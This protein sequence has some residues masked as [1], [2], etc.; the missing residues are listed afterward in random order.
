MKIILTILE[1][2]LLITG[3]VIGVLL[4]NYYD[5]RKIEG[6]LNVGKDKM[7]VTCFGEGE[8]TVIFE[9]GL[10]CSDTDWARVQP[11]ISKVAR[12]FSYNRID[13][14]RTTLSQVQE[15]HSLLN[16]TKV[17]GHYIIVAHSF[18]GLNARAY[19]G[20]YPNE[21]TVIIFVDCS[22]ESQI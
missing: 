3:T 6:V 14:G 15:L 22:H 4:K 7:Y 13:T 11:E 19:A 18:A 21:V 17:K 9:N 16:N 10:G 12:I 5:T 1:I 2:V 8:P 20:T